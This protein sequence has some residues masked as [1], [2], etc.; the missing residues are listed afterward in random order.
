[1]LWEF[2]MGEA[3]MLLKSGKEIQ[4]FKGSSPKWVFDLFWWV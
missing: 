3:S 2:L 4:S 1:M